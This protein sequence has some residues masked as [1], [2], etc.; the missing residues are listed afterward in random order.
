M[1]NILRFTI[2]GFLIL[3]MILIRL[4]QELLFYDPILYFFKNEEVFK[5]QFD[6]EKH[7]ISVS[8]RYFLNSLLSIGIIY[9]LFLN[10]R[11]IKLS[12]LVFSVFLVIF[13]PIYFLFILDEFEYSQM[14]GFYIRRF[15]IQPIMGIILILALFYLEKVKK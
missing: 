10:R 1:N 15:L 3:F 4:N 14:L 2:I 13:L 5:F 6:I 8:F 11:Y 12:A 7:L 9:F